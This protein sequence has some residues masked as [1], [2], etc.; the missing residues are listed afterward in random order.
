MQSIIFMAIP[1]LQI[2]PKKVKILK[3]NQ[4]KKLTLGHNPLHFNLIQ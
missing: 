2:K 1:Q 3:L 4:K